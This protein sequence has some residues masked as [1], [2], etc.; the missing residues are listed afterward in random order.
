MK[1]QP[2]FLVKRMKI[3]TT[4]ILATLVTLA[5]AS[6]VPKNLRLPEIGKEDQRYR[7]GTS[8]QRAE[9][10]DDERKIFNHKDKIEIFGITRTTTPQEACNK[11]KIQLK[12]VQDKPTEVI[13]SDYGSGCAEYKICKGRFINESDR[14]D[15]RS[16]FTVTWAEGC[17]KRLN[18]TG[19]YLSSISISD[20]M[21]NA[22]YTPYNEFSKSFMKYYSWASNM[23]CL[24][25]GSKRRCHKKVHNYTH[26]YT[27][28]IKQ[29]FQ[30][31]QNEI[32][33]KTIYIEW[34]ELPKKLKRYKKLKPAF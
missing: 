22:T 3:L 18:N 10:L 12:T 34:E 28:D 20:V 15:T 7:V 13:Q 9:R 8:L 29:Y 27:I 11:L 19:D 5:V 26:S 14:L 33:R 16:L 31:N 4:I 17:T 30:G 21:F 32:Q 2:Q 23:R 24:Q 6:E 25:R 1:K